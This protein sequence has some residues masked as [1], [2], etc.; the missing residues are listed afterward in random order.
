MTEIFYNHE[1][2]QV[3]WRLF[4]KIIIVPSAKLIIKFYSKKEEH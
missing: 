4:V 2:L 3:N 1:S